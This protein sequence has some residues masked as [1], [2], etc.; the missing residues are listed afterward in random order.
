MAVKKR[1]RRKAQ[2]ATEVPP[3]FDDKKY[4]EDDDART[5]ARA[6]EIMSNRSRFAGAK[7]GAKRIIKEEEDRVKGLRTVAQGRKPRG[8]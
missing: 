6:N 2:T 5:L 4:Q 1:T 7:R 3:M 8:K